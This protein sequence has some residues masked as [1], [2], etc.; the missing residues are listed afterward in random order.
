M[1]MDNKRRLDDPGHSVSSGRI[2]I[3]LR[4][5]FCNVVQ[6]SVYIKTLTIRS[7]TLYNSNVEKARGVVNAT[8]HEPEVR[9]TCLAARCATSTDVVAS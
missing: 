7:N 5:L 9:L 8:Y 4:E 1:A 3:N 6:D 2:R